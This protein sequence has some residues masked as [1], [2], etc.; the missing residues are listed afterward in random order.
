MPPMGAMRVRRAAEGEEGGV[1]AAGAS[2]TAAAIGSSVGRRG[3][4][5]TVARDGGVA[6]RARRWVVS[7]PASA[8]RSWRV[9]VEADAE[10]GGLGTGGG[11]EVGEGFGGA[12]EGPGGGL[13]EHGVLA[14]VGLQFVDD[15]TRAA[16]VPG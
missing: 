13:V 15:L 6:G 7:L 14:L 3:D 8:T 5:R 16:V 4:A 10:E 1:V 11:L 12:V 9:A 2:T